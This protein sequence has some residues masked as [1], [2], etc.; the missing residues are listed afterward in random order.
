MPRIMVAIVAVLIVVGGAYFWST[1]D[2]KPDTPAT[3]ET[4]APAAA[5]ARPEEAPA[6]P[7]TPS[8]PA[9]A[10]TASPPREPVPPRQEA[11]LPAKTGLAAMLAERSVGNADAPLTIHEYISLNCPHCATFHKEVY[12]K[13]KA[14]YVD[15]GKARIVV[16][17]FPLGPVAMT[18]HMLARCAPENRYF[19][20]VS[21]IFATQP[22]W[23]VSNTPHQDLRRIAQLSGLSA[24]DAD[25]CLANDALRTGI[26]AGAKLAHE[27]YGIDGTPAFLI[28]EY[29]IPGALPFE[30]FQ[31]IIDKALAKAGTK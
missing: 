3:E 22:Q 7:A 29:K 8:E 2:R 18:G 21:A 24:A 11:S 6:A 23:R 19:G 12:P 10:D 30:D 20:M 13:I 26:E 1:T 17:D 31:D 16:H 14:A 9:P 4:H 27:K 25:A 15:T 28:G 5:P